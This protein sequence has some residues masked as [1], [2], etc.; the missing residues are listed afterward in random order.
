MFCGL[1]RGKR[2]EHI[3]NMKGIERNE[4]ICKAVFYHEH[5]TLDE[6]TQ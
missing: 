4:R 2:G 5:R 6:R 3:N 1:M